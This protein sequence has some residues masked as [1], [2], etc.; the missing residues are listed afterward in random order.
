MNTIIENL[1]GMNHMSDQV[2]AYDLLFST[3]T[4]VKNTAVAI[5]EAAT[6]EVRTVLRKQLD[7]AIDLHERLSLHM[8]NK[9]MYHAYNIGEQ[10]QLD[11][12]NAQTALNLGG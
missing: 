6:P 8:I 3:K 7:A 9:G 2:I 4:G 12:K 11:M 10:I 1:T 5:T